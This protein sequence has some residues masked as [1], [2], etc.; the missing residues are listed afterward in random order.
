MHVAFR[1]RLNTIRSAACEIF[2][3]MKLGDGRKVSDDDKERCEQRLSVFIT[4]DILPSSKGR[5]K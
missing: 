4:T 1:E 5:R 2:K 3:S